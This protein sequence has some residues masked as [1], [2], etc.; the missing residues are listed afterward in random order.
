MVSGLHDPQ[1]KAD[2]CQPD[3]WCEGKLSPTMQFWGFGQVPFTWRPTLTDLY[4]F[5]SSPQ[6]CMEDC[7][8]WWQVTVHPLGE[9]Y[10]GSPANVTDKA[11]VR[12]Q[13]NLADVFTTVLK[14]R[15][16][17]EDGLDQL[18][19]Y[20]DI[21][22]G[23]SFTVPPSVRV[24]MHIVAAK[25]PDYGVVTKGQIP[26]NLG[27]SWETL[28]SASIVPVHGPTFRPLYVSETIEVT[29]SA[30]G[31]VPVPPHA[32]SVRIMQEP[33]T[34]IQPH[35]WVDLTGGI[36]G[37]IDMI[38]GQ[39]STH[40]ISVPGPAMWV[41]LGISPPGELITYTLIWQVRL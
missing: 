33:S 2:T 27:N 18:G 6:S 3:R 15:V 5:I 23:V 14:A 38:P 22:G 32:H 39:R 29:D 26:I 10:N 13:V 11:N 21:N 34:T 20:F 41:A 30:V 19:V 36:L 24:N 37:Q 35:N 1:Q 17:W 4:P 12:R 7:P 16:T 25:R 9:L 8:N 28:L 31:L 40:E